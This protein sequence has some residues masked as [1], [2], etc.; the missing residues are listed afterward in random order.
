MRH[1]EQFK[2]MFR[3]VDMLTLS[4]TPIPRTLYTAL[5]GA[6]A[7]STIETA[8]MNRLPVQTAVCPYN[9]QL[10]ADAIER[11]LARNGQVFF[12][13]NRVQSIHDMEATLRRLAPRARIVVGHGQ[14]DKADLECV[15]RDFVNGKADVLLSTTIIESGI[16]IP[17]ANTII[18]D[19][20]DR[21]GLA[22]LYQLPCLC[23]PHAA[24]GSS[25][26]RR[27][28]QARL[29]HQAVYRARQRV[30]DCHA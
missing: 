12:L 21:F 5:M 11:E 26:H 14:M 22:D 6:R 7:M 4:A 17:N 28:P 13:H 19:R 15:M 3:M 10:I 20:A 2:R 27:R 16:D 29:R 8:P 9:E 18:I 25:L 1:K 30:Q 23:L 24:E